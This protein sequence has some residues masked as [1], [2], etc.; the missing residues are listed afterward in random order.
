MARNRP[1]ST[2][3][4]DTMT[5]HKVIPRQKTHAR[6]NTRGEKKKKKRQKQPLQKLHMISQLHLN[7]KSIKD[8]DKPQE[9]QNLYS[10]FGKARQ[11]IA[12][13]HSFLNTSLAC[14]AEFFKHNSRAKRLRKSDYAL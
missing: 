4:V 11:R 7:R 5:A 1:S 6:R 2:G 10:N 9:R 12:T 3:L 14:T 8:N 13:R